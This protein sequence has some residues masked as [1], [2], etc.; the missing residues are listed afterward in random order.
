MIRNYLPIA[1]RSLLKNKASSLIN[2]FGLA[3]S[4]AVCILIVQFTSF[5]F[6]YDRFHQ[7]AESIYR[8]YLDI[9]KNGSR[10]A[11][12]ARVSPG[13]AAFFQD[14]FP[15]IDAYTRMV[16]LGP[17]GVLS[18]KDRYSGESDI[19]LVD[20]SFFEVFS[21]NL[22]RGNKQTAF[23]EPFCVVITENTA[24]TIFG[25]EDALGKSVV[26]NAKNFDGTSLPFKVTGVIENFPTNSH[27][28]PG[29]LI[30]YPTLFEF[31]GHRF[32]ESW[33]WNETYTYFRL[34]PNVNPLD[35]ESRFP[36]VVHQFNRQLAEQQLDWIYKLQPVTDIHLHSDLQHEVSVNGK[37]TYVYMLVT[38]GILIILIAY[39]NYVNLVTVKAMQR[40]KEVG[41]RKVSGARRTQ[42][43]IQFFVESLFV[44]GIALM[45]AIILSSLAKPLI[46]NLFDITFSDT[47]FSYLP[48][49]LGFSALLLAV[50]CGSGIYPA[51]VLSGYKPIMALKG[52]YARGKSGE[53]IRKLFV[54]GQ[55]AV[56]MILIALTLAAIVQVQYMQQQ[57]LGFN[58]EQIVV[59]KSPKAHD[60][61]YGGNF[62]GFQNKISLLGHVSSVSASNVV[63]GQ[64]I[65]WYD[66]QVTVNDKDASG[67]FSMLAVGQ[68][69]FSH[70]DIR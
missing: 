56:A 46:V 30:S 8:V 68:N 52:G 15:L 3:I 59:I 64:E 40:A 69:Y 49:W 55:F 11:Q 48:I 51:L 41:V 24:R 14:E 4:I 13:V 50:V 5:E 19:L 6:S 22:V 26:I 66:D 44:N 67:V 58:P 53:T 61:G 54:T 31:V 27:L 2:I 36:N 21:F 39:I 12:S 45:L 65:Y 28:H 62:S 32:D 18:Y 33:S 57:S 7:R 16:I 1:F 20:S 34:R 37:A 60:Y 63:P 47:L 9:Y 23:T 25:S 10:E 29:V 17:D 43:I 38:I 70:Y 42:I 35:L